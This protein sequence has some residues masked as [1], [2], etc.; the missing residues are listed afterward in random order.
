MSISIQVTTVGDEDLA[1]RLLL[2][3]RTD[4]DE[5][6]ES[7]GAL[8]E[9]QT[10]RRIQDTKTGPDGKSWKPW[11]D[12]YARTRHGGHSLLMNEGNL[13]DSIQHLIHGDELEVGSNLVYARTQ[14]LGDTRRGFGR[15]D[16]TI[17]ARPYLGVNAADEDEVVAAIEDLVGE[18]LR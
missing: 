10:R 13:L 3:E 7:V 8:V 12:A 18:V 17:P 6:L 15:L 5:V 11:S 4:F 1:R 2:L 9:S 16:V 14:Q